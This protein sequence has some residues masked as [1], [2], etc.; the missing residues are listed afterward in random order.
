[1]T[2]VR[3]TTPEEVKTWIDEGSAVIVDVRE[4]HEFAQAHIPG[5]RMVPLSRFDPA[6]LPEV[7][8]DKHL[9]LHCASGVRCGTAASALKASGFQ[10]D[11][12][13]L[14]GGIINWYRSGGALESGE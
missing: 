5:A 2:T 12:N 10:G 1:M 13:R 9:V 7:P 4:P 6:A 8:A 3:M 11:I 14:E